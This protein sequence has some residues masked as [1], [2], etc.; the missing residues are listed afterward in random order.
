MRIPK[1]IFFMSLVVGLLPIMN[2]NSARG[3]TI[4]VV[5]E[6]QT[7]T[8]NG[9]V[10]TNTAPGPLPLSGVTTSVI[11]PNFAGD[12]TDFVTGAPTFAGGTC[13]PLGQILAG[14][15]TCTVNL[16]FNTP[17]ADVNEPVDF[18]VS[19]I[20]LSWIFDDGPVQSQIFEIQ[21]NDAP[22]VPEPESVT[23]LGL[24][25]V[26]LLGATFIAKRR[27]FV[28]NHKPSNSK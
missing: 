21:V 15:A 17:A 19:Q 11:N 25:M 22:P 20:G 16:T 8:I 1:K 10:I 9:F 27:G 24:G 2:P 14:G 28:E 3:V 18:G 23:L 12:A 26:V 7:L 6:G 5:Q 4:G 13:F